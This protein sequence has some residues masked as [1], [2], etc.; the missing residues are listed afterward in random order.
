MTCNKLKNKVFTIFNIFDLKQI[1]L[2][3]TNRK[4]H[5]VHFITRH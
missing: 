4:K 2:I 3:L 1:I 5:Y